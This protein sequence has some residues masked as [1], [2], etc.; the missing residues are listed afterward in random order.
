[1][2][3]E[4]ELAEYYVRSCYPVYYEQ[5]KEKRMFLCVAQVQTRVSDLDDGP[6]RSSFSVMRVDVTA[7]TRSPTWIRRHCINA[8]CFH[9]ALSIYNFLSFLRGIGQNGKASDSSP[10]E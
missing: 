4:N 10:E 5:T 8:L 1:M 3:L 7:R 2:S 9:E 6:R